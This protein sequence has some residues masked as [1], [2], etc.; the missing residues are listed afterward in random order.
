MINPNRKLDE[1]AADIIADFLDEKMYG[2][3]ENV[4]R[5]YDKARQVKGLDII[6]KMKG[7]TYY[8]DEKAAV[9]Y[10][11][12]GL[13]TFALELYTLDRFGNPH[14]GWLFD[15]EKLNDSFLFV[16]IDKADSNRLTH[17][18][19][20]HSVEVALVRKEKIVEHL[21]RL[22]WD[23]A[24]ILRK[25]ERIW[26]NADEPQ[27]NIFVHGCKFVCSRKLPEQ[28]VN[29]ILP[30]KTYIELSDFHTTITQ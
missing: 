8:C 9:Q 29:I 15:T 5:V 19:Q 14:I 22:G 10:I 25:A 7:H 28:P 21:K 6:F 4:E 27:G 30:R 13:G 18:S 12:Q 11:N 17:K 16:W 2:Q 3:F 24:K 20:L 26:R 1:S 23:S